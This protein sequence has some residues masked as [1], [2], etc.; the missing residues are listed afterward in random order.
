[1]IKYLGE[2]NLR[3]ND[4]V[5]DIGGGCNPFERADVVVDNVIGEW[6]KRPINVKGGYLFEG[7]KK[8]SFI[9]ASIEKL[10]F[11]EKQF[12]FVYCSHTLEHTE[13]PEKACEEIMRVGKRGYI[14]TPEITNETILG[15]H[16][17]KWFVHALDK[18]TILFFPKLDQHNHYKRFR[19]PY[20]LYFGDMDNNDT[21]NFAKMRLHKMNPSTGSF[22][23]VQ[24]IWK[25]K[26][27]YIVINK[28]NKIITNL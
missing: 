25:D 2:W 9:Q 1:M 7:D 28:D 5:V 13:F 23:Y 22:W 14:T 10:P 20:K 21:H 19:E 3:E 15:D 18:N 11:K 17:H 26:F 24:M 6:K 12:D 16:T 8:Y 27:N 4:L